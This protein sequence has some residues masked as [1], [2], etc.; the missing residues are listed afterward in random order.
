MSEILQQGWFSVGTKLLE[1]EKQ[2]L[3]KQG[4]QRSFTSWLHVLSKTLDLKPSTLWK[5]LKIVKMVD[6]IN[7]PT[8]NVN[9]KN[10]TGLEQIA[11]I[12]D[13]NQNTAE[14]IGLIRQ[15]DEKII[16]VA[17][18]TKLARAISNSLPDVERPPKE[19]VI[20]HVGVKKLF[21]HNSTKYF[22]SVVTPRA[23]LSLSFILLTVFYIK[24]MY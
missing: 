15:L 4:Q 7:L 12:Y 23:T 1:V 19:P 9:L 8:D 20:D 21:W 16:N 18:I 10:V 17:D 11:R 24:D 5:Y 14:A 13:A 2:E 3:Y 6:K 22:L